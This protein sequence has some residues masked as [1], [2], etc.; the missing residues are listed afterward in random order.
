MT[1]TDADLLQ[2]LYR[3]GQ[4]VRKARLTR[5]QPSVI[6]SPARCNPSKKLENPRRI[7]DN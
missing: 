7:W 1:P 5:P 6:Y 2:Q 4:D 3:T